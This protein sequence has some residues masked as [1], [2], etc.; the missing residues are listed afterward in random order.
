M[1]DSLDP[2]TLRIENMKNPE[3]LIIIP[4]YNEEETIGEAITAVSKYTDKVIIVNDG[5]TDRTEEIAREKGVRIVHHGVNCGLGKAMQDGIDAALKLGCDIIVTFDADMQYDADE[6]PQLLKPIMEDKA[7]LVLGSRFS[8]KIEQMPSIKRVGNRLFTRVTEWLA[9]VPITDAQTGFRAMR[10]E[11]AES[12]IL[13][14]SYTY[15]QEMIIRSVKDGFRIAEV[16]ITFRKRQSG[17]SRLISSPIQYGI[18]ALQIILRTY[19]DYHP[20]KFFGAIGIALLSA[21][22]IIGV[23]LVNIHLTEGLTGHFPTIV[24]CAILSISGVQVL[25]FG[26][27]ADMIANLRKQVTRRK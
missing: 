16:P 11:V 20:L 10:R 22:I 25:L 24:L 12:L 26:F 6:V 27:M 3:V 14:S 9:G 7:D 17:K 19:R 4:A 2:R 5:S 21:G 15:T 8:G 13:T 1:K 18:R 23:Y